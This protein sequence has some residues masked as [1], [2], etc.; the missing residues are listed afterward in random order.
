MVRVSKSASYIVNAPV[1]DIG[2]ASRN[3]KWNGKDVYF[4]AASSTCI[5]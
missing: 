3:G 1:V 4:C 5:S 2:V